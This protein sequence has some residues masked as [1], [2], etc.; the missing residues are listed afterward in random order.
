MP[1]VVV[2]LHRVVNLHVL[3]LVI[4]NDLESRDIV[5]ALTI[6]IGV[7]KRKGRENAE[8]ASVSKNPE[9]EAA[10]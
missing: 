5:R 2:R 9:G 8:V 1:C 10:P 6:T 3:Q 7:I 4:R